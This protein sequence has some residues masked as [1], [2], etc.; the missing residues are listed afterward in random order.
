MKNEFDLLILTKY[1]RSGPS[2]R[3]RILQFIPYLESH[4]FRCTVQSLHTPDYLA[5]VYSGRARS[6]LYY[7]GR[8]LARAQAVARASHYSAVFVQKEI[9]P[10]VPPWFELVLSATGA[11]VVYDIDDAIYL[12][13]SDSKHAA[14][15]VILGGK[16]PAALRRSTAVLAGNPFLHEYA[17]RYNRQTVLFPT[18]VDPTRYTTGES[19]G[20]IPVVGW[21]GSPETVRYLDERANMLRDVA[22][23]APHR[24]RVIGAPASAIRG[25]NVES[26]PWS[27]DTEA[28]E[29]SRCDIGIM[30]LPEGA[31]AQGKC[32][33]KLLQYMACGLPVVSSPEGGAGGIVE[34]GVNGYIA[35]SDEEWRTYLAALITNP[36]L[37][38]IMG[39]EGRKRIEGHFSLETW[40]PRMAE[41]LAQCIRGERVEDAGL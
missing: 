10:Y 5:A 32:G 29:L 31:W 15:R 41:I 37:R 22:R 7:V 12:R 21:I 17:S 23:A 1:D 40:A 24:V 34:H 4:G 30:P 39:R 16:I 11:K 33:L 8:L 6:P 35:R 36:E 28:R 25:L 3:Y 14:V 18:V 38:R 26:V 20:D 19:H 27:E 2:S 9:A 13:Y